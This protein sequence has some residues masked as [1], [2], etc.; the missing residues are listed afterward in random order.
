[1]SGDHGFVEDTIPVDPLCIPGLIHERAEARSSPGG[2]MGAPGAVA[3]WVRQGGTAAP[4]RPCGACRHWRYKAGQ[5][6]VTQ[7]SVRLDL[8]DLGWDRYTEM[9]EMG[10]CAQDDTR[11]SHRL[12]TCSAWS[13]L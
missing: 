4:T 13:P 2:I 6:V 3:D 8:N 7:L 9:G 5:E 11:L 12:A 1:M 10:R